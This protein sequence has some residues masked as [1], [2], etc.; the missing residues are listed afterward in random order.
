MLR[1]RE[2]YGDFEPDRDLEG[3]LEIYLDPAEPGLAL[4]DLDM[5]MLRPSVLP[6][7]AGL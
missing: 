5:D 7:L 2:R 6:L 1:L 4:R 3:L